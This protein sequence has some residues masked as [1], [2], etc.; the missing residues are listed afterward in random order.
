M[1][2][3]GEKSGQTGDQTQVSLYRVDHC[4]TPEESSTST[5][6]RGGIGTM[7]EVRTWRTIRVQATMTLVTNVH[8]GKGKWQHTV[9][10]VIP[11]DSD[12]WDP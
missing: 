12:F 5:V 6:V 4:T 3:G 8:L 2:V 10:E 7:E 11:P 1:V 9:E